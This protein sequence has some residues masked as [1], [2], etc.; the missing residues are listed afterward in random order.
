M[1][2]RLLTDDNFFQEL[3]AG[4]DDLIDEYLSGDLS[5]SERGLFDDYFMTTAE[6]QEKLRFAR[7][8][9]KFVSQAGAARSNATAAEV[10]AQVRSK[11]AQPEPDKRGWF[12]FLPWQNPALSYSL[13]AAAVVVL[14]LATVLIIRNLSSPSAGPGKVLAVELAPGLSRGDEGMKQVTLS[15]DT[16]TLQLQLRFPNPAAYQKYRAILQTTDGREISRVDDLGRDPVSNDRIN[17][18]L[19]ANNLKPADYNVKL[20]GLNQQGEYEDVA[21][22]Y[23]R[24]TK[25]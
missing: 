18:P 17:C 3:L 8:L 11:V 20:S 21:R 16:T 9:K 22:Y 14:V 4:E 10:I 5:A 24:V 19:P 15:S 7:G 25:N 23:F 6:R 1:E 12:S 2:E 13:G